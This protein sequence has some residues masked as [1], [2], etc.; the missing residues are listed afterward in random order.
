MTEEVLIKKIA[1]CMC[2]EFQSVWILNTKNDTMKLISE[3]RTDAVK[4]RVD[5]AIAANSYETIRKW[6]LE[7]CV[8]ATDR[9]R[10]DEQTTVDNIL[11]MLADTESFSVE[12]T[13]IADGKLNYNQIMY[14][15]LDF[16]DQDNEY[17]V[18][19]FRD[20][21]VRK[22]A[23]RDDLTGVYT[24]QVF[25]QKAEQLLNQYPD[26]Q[27][28]LMISDIVDFKEI[29]ETY[30]PSIGDEILKAAGRFLAQ[31]IRN[32]VLVGRFGGD[33]F[34]IIASHDY[35][36]AIN[37]PQG[38]Q[39]YENYEQEQN[40]LPNFVTKYGIYEGVD[41]KKSIVSTC[42][43]AHS[44][45]NSIKHQYGKTIAFYDDKIRREIETNRK[46]EGSMHQALKKDQFKVYYQPKHDAITGKMVGAEALIRWI[47]PEYGFMS[48]GE[49]IPLF[50]KNGFIV[51]TDG[52]VWKRT[53]ENLRRWIDKGLNPVPISVNASKLTFAQDELLDKM[54]QAVADNNIT[55]NLLHLEITETMMTDDVDALIKK[56]T[57]IREAGYQIE[58]D[59][60][61]AGYSSIN[62]LSTLP[63]DVIK[64]DM[65]FMKQ[66]GDAKREKVLAACI[67][68]AK[69][70]GYKTVSEGVEHKEQCDVL[71]IL[72]VDAIQGYYYSKP[73]P[74]EDFEE[75]IRKNV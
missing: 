10:V 50:E 63:L 19:G 7:K 4:Y 13:R 72:G 9:A 66:F 38:K 54:Q 21:D 67:K 59:D 11:R 20:I 35:M 75:Y 60:F 31:K 57:A 1:D 53:C 55:S 37:K 74:E 49:F 30:G 23:E 5:N 71:C 41:H 45:L 12:Y 36:V 39:E 73:L 18:L 64:L 33:Q 8:D 44:A 34:V 17:V 48:P 3:D 58:L 27:F 65:S 29:N 32:D 70:L 61:G 15:R 25:F 16:M 62:I 40:Q 56:L 6:Y 14:S 28:D 26:V 24:R 51:E 68:L 22:K 42:D 69:E 52:Y 43:K 2:A 47:H 46:I